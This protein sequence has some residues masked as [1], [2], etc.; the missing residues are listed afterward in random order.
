MGKIYYVMGKSSSGK[1]TIYK[2]LLESHPQFRTIVPYTTRPIREGERDGVEYYFVNDDRLREMQEAGQ[3]IEVR[4]YNTKCG[5]WTYFTADD[6]QISLEAHD[7]LVIGT[8]V[9][10]QALREYFG[11]EKIVPVYIEV[12]DGLRL[13]RAVE[14]E[15]RQEEPKYA[16]LCRRFLADSEDFSEENLTRAGITRRFENKEL[17]ACLSS[18]EAYIREQAGTVPGETHGS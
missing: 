11:R 12:E 4:S 8:L 10:Y 1:D 18:I 7:Y 13:S 2:K 17:S 3:V 6:G 14:R 15:R 5:I 9:S 16:E